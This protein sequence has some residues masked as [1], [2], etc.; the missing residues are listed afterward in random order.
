MHIDR[1]EAMFL[2][3]AGA[4]LVIFGLAILIAVFG[5]GVQLPGVSGQIA[6][7]ELSDDPG[8]GRPGLRE[9]YP[10]RY[11]V[12][13]VASA[14][15]GWRFEPAEVRVP[16]GSQVTFFIASND[17]THG[18]K[19]VDTNINIMVIPGQISEV[20]YTFDE[21]GTYQFLCQEYCGASHHLMGGTIIVEEA[22]DD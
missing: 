19:V 10:G 13:M 5:L 9:I 14:S 7:G 8:F 22:D 16:A 6:P 3:L 20:T 18:F 12:Y 21:P 17:I 11:E 1:L 4:M 2:W 15:A